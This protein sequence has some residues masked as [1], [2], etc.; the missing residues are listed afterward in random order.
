MNYK[1]LALRIVVATSIVVVWAIAGTI[2]GVP[3]LIQYSVSGMVG[4]LAVAGDI[5]AG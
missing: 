2:L 5:D 3:P 4:A 1:R